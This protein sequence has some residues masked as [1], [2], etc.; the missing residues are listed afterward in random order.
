MK[1][2]Y[3]MKVERQLKSRVVSSQYVLANPS[4][5]GCIKIVAVI[6]CFFC[7]NATTTWINTKKFEQ[8]LVNIN[9]GWLSEVKK[10]IN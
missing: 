1:L 2:D 4:T 3:N 8:K 7:F 10:C 9:I 6:F 5:W